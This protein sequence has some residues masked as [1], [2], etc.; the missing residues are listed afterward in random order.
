MRFK[1]T[2]E[3]S[4]CNRS[5][6]DGRDF[7]PYL[8]RTVAEGTPT[9]FGIHV[10]NFKKLLIGEAQSTS[11]PVWKQSVIKVSRLACGQD[12]ISEHSNL[13]SH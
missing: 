10:W 9:K 6:V 5:F 2:F 13:N 7:I 8:G 4:Y 12:F 1:P 11:W 3:V